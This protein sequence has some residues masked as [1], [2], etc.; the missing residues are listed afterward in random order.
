MA[1]NKSTFKIVVKDGDTKYQLDKN[2][3]YNSKVTDYVAEFDTFS[4]A[5]EEFTGYV[6]DDYNEGRVSLILTPAKKK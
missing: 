4:A 6:N 3:Q 5:L 1:K 2:G